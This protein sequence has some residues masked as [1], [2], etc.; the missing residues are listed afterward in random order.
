MMAKKSLISTQYKAK[1]TVLFTTTYSE[2]SNFRLIILL[3]FPPFNF[4]GNDAVKYIIEADDATS[5]NKGRFTIIFLLCCS[6]SR[7]L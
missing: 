4:F 7:W 3:M 2:K 6:S 1:Q 5:D